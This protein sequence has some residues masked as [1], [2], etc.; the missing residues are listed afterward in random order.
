[1]LVVVVGQVVL[2]VQEHLLELL[3]AVERALFLQLLAREFFTLVAE[4]VAV[5]LLVALLQ[6]DKAVLV[7]GAQAQLLP[8]QMAQAELQILVEEGL[9]LERLLPRLAQVVLVA[10]ELSSSVTHKSIQHQ[11]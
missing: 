1:L 4:A 2:A 8:I 5:T 11:R 10:L 9:V 3:V 6:V 7:A